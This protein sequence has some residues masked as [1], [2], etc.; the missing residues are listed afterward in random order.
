MTFLTLG[1]STVFCAS[2]H[3][4][5]NLYRL[6]AVGSL[7]VTYPLARIA[8]VSIFD[9]QQCAR[10]YHSLWRG[11]GIEGCR[12]GNAIPAINQRAYIRKAGWQRLLLK[13]QA[14][15]WFKFGFDEESNKNCK[16]YLYHMLAK[17]NQ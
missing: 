5:Y 16:Q 1:S 6:P 9:E 12:V 14:L 15:Y 13:A 7:T 8:F 17:A 4:I 2:K 10:K 3:C 11:Y